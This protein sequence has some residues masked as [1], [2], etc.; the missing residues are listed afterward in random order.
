MKIAPLFASATVVFDQSRH[1]DNEV[2]V[3]CVRPGGAERHLRLL[4]VT[5]RGGSSAAA[6]G[7][8]VGL[9][10]AVG[11]HI[12]AADRAATSATTPMLH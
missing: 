12:H 2:K 6:R 7:D 11:G 10:L 8:C 1:V 4:R 3:F 9:G 5:V